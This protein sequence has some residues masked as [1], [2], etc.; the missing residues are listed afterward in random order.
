MLA[1][2][3]IYMQ[4]T[5]ITQGECDFLDM[6][7]QSLRAANPQLQGLSSTVHRAKKLLQL[8]P[9]LGSQCCTCLTC[10]IFHATAECYT[11]ADLVVRIQLYVCHTHTHTYIVAKLI[12]GSCNCTCDKNNLYM[13]DTSKY[14]LVPI[15]TTF[16]RR[17]YF[18]VLF[19]YQNLVQ[20]FYQTQLISHWIGS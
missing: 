16:S 2:N 10:T 15:T 7:A 8:N 1:V 14:F 19:W 11:G 5:V 12:I 6:H 13:F 18:I 9:K 4:I 3:I 17:I 20:L